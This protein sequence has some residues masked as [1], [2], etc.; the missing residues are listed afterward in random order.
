MD[1]NLPTFILIGPGRAGTTWLYE[2]LRSHP[3]VFMARGTKETF[4][5]DREFHR[6]IEWYQKFFEGSTG[7]CAIGEATNTYIYNPWVPQRIKSIIPDV[8]LLTCLRNPLER[9]QSVY[10]YRKRAGTLNCSFEDALDNHPD[11]LLDNL[12]WTLISHFLDYF[13]QRQLFLFFYD[14]LQADS[15]RFIKTVYS[16]IGVDDEYVPNVVAQRVNVGVGARLAGTSRLFRFMA[17]S[18]RSAGLHVLLDALKRN[19]WLGNLAYRKL[20]KSER[21]ILTPD[22]RQRLSEM[23]QPEI[24]HLAEFTGR[25]LSEWLHV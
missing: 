5:F 4:F 3:Q 15:I 13:D 22:L 10:F 17:D 6:G 11:L 25:D 12:Y 21:S 24:E 2:V 19:V 20:D 16:A 9:I 23:Y 1:R 7:A 8:R 18:M 14:D